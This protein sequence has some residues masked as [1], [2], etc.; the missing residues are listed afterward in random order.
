MR[1][2]HAWH[3]QV[4]QSKKEVASALLQEKEELRLQVAL[5]SYCIHV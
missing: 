1:A 4:Q 3:N 5:I 2:H